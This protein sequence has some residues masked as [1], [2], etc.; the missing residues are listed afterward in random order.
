MLDGGSW[1]RARR[2]K[3][4]LLARSTAAAARSHLHPPAARACQ[5]GGV[6]GHRLSEHRGSDRRPQLAAQQRLAIAKVRSQK[7]LCVVG[8]RAESVCQ[9]TCAR[10]RGR[11]SGDRAGRP[12]R[13]KG[14]ANHIPHVFRPCLCRTLRNNEAASSAAQPYPNRGSAT[15]GN[16]RA[17][18]GA[19]G[20]AAAPPLPLP[21]SSR[22]APAAVARWRSSWLSSRGPAKLRASPALLAA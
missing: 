15:S 10:A 16:H 4:A 19:D 22:A 20:A 9:H 8:T 12:C 1:C 5:R 17:A 14:R 18:R 11:D 3:A 6:D 21:A 2:G 13:H 7:G